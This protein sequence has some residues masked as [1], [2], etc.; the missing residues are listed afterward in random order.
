MLNLVNDLLDLARI[1][2]GRIEMNPEPFAVA[3][4][5]TGCCETV[6]PLTK[7]GV[8]LQRDIAGDIGE[9]YTDQGRLC[10]ILI[11][12]LSNALKFTDEGQVIIRAARDDDNLILTVSDTGTG[13]PQE[14]LATIFE[15]FKQVRGSDPQHKGTGLGLPITQA[16]T[17]LLGGNISVESEMGKGSTFTVYIPATHE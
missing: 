2:S 3:D 13:I 14:E 5:I 9:A 8:E 15:E 12:L 16:F 1:E 10:Q 4:A 11:N 7:P 6:A 17:R